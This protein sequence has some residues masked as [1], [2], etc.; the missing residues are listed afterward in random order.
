DKD[1]QQLEFIKN[2]INFNVIGK[3][4]PKIKQILLQTYQSIWY[5]FN[6]TKAEWEQLEYAGPLALYLRNYE[7]EYFNDPSRIAQRRGLDEET[8]ARELK[9]RDCYVYGLMVLN[10]S[11]PKNLSLGLIPHTIT[12]AYPA[13]YSGGYEFER[14]D[15]LLI[16]KNWLDEIY[17]VWI[18]HPQDR[19]RFGKLI[20][21]CLSNPP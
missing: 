17:G 7:W 11:S 16:I 10:R 19:E 21:Y 9:L 5:K 12:D 6:E 2:I 15:E 3:Y 20:E 14:K 13:F 1:E 18:H 4:D 8:I